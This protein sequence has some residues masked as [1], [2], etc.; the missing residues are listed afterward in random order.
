[1][2]FLLFL[3]YTVTIA[4]KGKLPLLL[5]KHFILIV[6]L[7]VSSLFALFIGYTA[8]H[9]LTAVHLFAFLIVFDV[10]AGYALR[11]KTVKRI[12]AIV[13]AVLAVVLYVK[14]LDIRKLYHNAYYAFEERCLRGDGTV[15]GGC[16]EQLA[17]K[18]MFNRLYNNYA[19]FFT[20]I[21][22]DYGKQM[23]SMS[24]THGQ[25]N[26]LVR[27][28][29]P[30]PSDSIAKKCTNSTMVAPSLFLLHGGY[31]VFRSDRCMQKGDL[32]VSG[33]RKSGFTF[34]SVSDGTFTADE[35]FCHDGRYYYLF[36]NKPAIVHIDSVRIKTLR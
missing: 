33:R 27:N 25:S 32:E 8:R 34:R 20:F 35:T 16:F 28:V 4:F 23:L 11:H 1:M 21:G 31:Y 5:N 9:Q 30:L 18:M 14:V 17:D 26:S 3:A 24:L 6:S 10:W 19:T 13:M 29:L 2:P 12:I 15:D 22:Q 7:L 36:G